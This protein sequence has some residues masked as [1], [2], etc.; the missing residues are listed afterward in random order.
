MVKLLH[1]LAA[2]LLAA[3]CWVANAADSAPLRIGVVGLTHTHVHWLLG[4]EQLK[5][6]EIV[7]I[8]E[9]NRDDLL[10]AGHIGD[11]RKVVV[12]DGH[13]GPKKLGVNQEFLDWLGD[14]VDEATIILTYPQAQAIV[15]ASWNWPVARK[16]LEIYGVQGQLMADNRHQLRT[17]LSESAEE[18]TLTLPERTYPD[19][20]P[21]AYFKALI[22]GRIT[23][24]KYDPS[25]IDNNMIVMEILDAAA[26]SARQGKTIQLKP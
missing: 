20:D 17:R 6:I 10:R 26:R 13:K 12:H 19:N 4:R 23:P 2:L 5:D 24:G 15:Q 22:D 11:V 25:S 8:V 7:G 1:A 21:F 9:K 16:D 18:K 14:P 3:S